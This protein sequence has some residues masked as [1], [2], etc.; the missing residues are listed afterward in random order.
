[1]TA[2]DLRRIRGA[3]ADGLAVR[4]GLVITD[5]IIRDRAA[6]L[7]EYIRSIVD[8]IVTAALKDAARGEVVAGTIEPIGIVRAPRQNPGDAPKNSEGE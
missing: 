6:N 7:T 5:E 1:V 2:D 4:R 8:D 3:L